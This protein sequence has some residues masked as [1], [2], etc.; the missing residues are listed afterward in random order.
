MHE[1]M[2]NLARYVVIVLAV[3]FAVLGI[4]WADHVIG[5]SPVLARGILGFAVIFFAARAALRSKTREGIE[6]IFVFPGNIGFFAL[7]FGYSAIF[8]WAIGQIVAAVK[9]FIYV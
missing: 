6:S 8:F 4:Y 1:M 3:I 9:Y 7:I 5:S 2:P